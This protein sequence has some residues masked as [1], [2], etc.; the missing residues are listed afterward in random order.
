MLLSW[1]NIAFFQAMMAAMRQAIG[2]G[3]FGAFRSEMRN[4]W[5]AQ[6]DNQRG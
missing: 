3:R 5:L 2:E 4:R 6:E 1:H